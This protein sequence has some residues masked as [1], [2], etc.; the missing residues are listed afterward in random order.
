M[1]MKQNQVQAQA[2]HVMPQEKPTQL[3]E[4]GWL[5]K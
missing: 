2:P 3:R 5:H 1:G 4:Q